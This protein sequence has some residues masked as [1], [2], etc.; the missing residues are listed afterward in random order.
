MARR[1]PAVT[2]GY[3]YYK[4]DTGTWL[5]RDPVGERWALNLYGF[6]GNE[7]TDEVDYLG[8]GGGQV[9]IIIGGIVL[10]YSICCVKDIDITEGER[11]GGY[12]YTEGKCICYH[13][14]TQRTV[15]DFR[16]FFFC[17]RDIDRIDDVGLKRDK[18][19]EPAVPDQSSADVCDTYCKNNY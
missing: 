6:V 14:S 2:S 13:Q 1:N 18:M 16:D 17:P 11:S 8:E 10:V 19:Y 3:R 15:I 7:P 5:S 9:V 4:P 12:V